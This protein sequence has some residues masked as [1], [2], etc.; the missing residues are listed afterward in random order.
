MDVFLVPVGAARHALYCEAAAPL[1][2]SEAD[3]RRTLRTRA[4]DTFRRALAEGEADGARDGAAVTPSRSR[5]R[6]AITTRL[7]EAVAEQRL[8][9]Y[10]RH[11]TTSGLVHP[12][13]MTGARALDVTRASLAADQTKHL[14]WCVIDTVLA[15]ASIPVALLPGPNFVG[16]YFVFRAVGHLYSWRGARHGLRG[17]TWQCRPTPHLTALRAA[18]AAG[19]VDRE[20]QVEAIAAAL[21]LDRL[22]AFVE[23]TARRN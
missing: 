5:F 3:G 18:L 12:D 13:D 23:H 7:A 19:G 22:A 1:A 9:W 8:L 15:I 21:G 4:V 6:R 14:R 10:L 2:V 17:V 16:Y 11:E 20:R